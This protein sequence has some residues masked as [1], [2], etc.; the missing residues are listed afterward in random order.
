[1]GETSPTTQMKPVESLAHFTGLSEPAERAR[2]PGL[3]AAALRVAGRSPLRARRP[4]VH[5]RL[6]Q[7]EGQR[8]AEPAPLR[9]QVGKQLNLVP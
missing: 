7:R 3:H 5:G 1:M 2:R 8:Q 6:P 4:A 9:R